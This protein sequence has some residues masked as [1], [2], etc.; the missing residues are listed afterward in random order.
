[1]RAHRRDAGGDVSREPFARRAFFDQPELVGARWWQES[2]A[3]HVNPVTRRKALAKI[4]SIG[5]LVGT[6]GLLVALVRRRPDFDETTIDRDALEL[7]K[8]QG[9]DVG[10]PGVSLDLP[11]RSAADVAG[12]LDWS[13]ALPGLAEALA[14]ARPELQP[15]YV[16][17]LFQALVPPT[18]ASLRAAIAPI[19]DADLDQAY[20][21]GQ[22]LAALFTDP[23]AP[24]RTAVVVD[25]PGPTAVAV[26]AGMADRFDP[27]FLFD[28][29]PHPAGVVP[30]QLALGAAVYYRPR[31]L[32]ARATRPAGAPPVFVGDD[33][34]LAPYKDQ[35]DRFDNRYLLKL[36][37]AARLQ[38][39]GIDRLFYVRPKGGE[40]E[41]DDLNDD[42][43]ALGRAGIQVKMVALDDFE[44]GDPATPQRYYWGGHPMTHVHFWPVYVG[45]YRAVPALP[46]RIA[47]S[48]GY[49]PAPRPTMFSS[50][51]IGGAAGIGRQKPSGFGRVSYRSEGGRSGSFGRSSSSWG[52]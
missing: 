42:F 3:T 30:S 18:S 25:A 16:P 50:R 32:A 13:D 37:S 52:G 34:R 45:G 5:F 38:A 26:A 33:Q 1:V 29:W 9:W 43:V 24:G 46:P 11:G 7:Q 19:H 22:A 27:V 6:A 41:L 15:Y 40:L 36:P 12:A 20:A 23:S 17:T 35:S 47:P 31:F 14:P 51:T 21:R 2:L 10:R 4:V 49:A 28:N 8:E 44:R 48:I 39:L